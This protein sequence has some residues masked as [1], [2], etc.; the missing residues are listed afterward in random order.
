MLVNARAIDLIR[1]YQSLR[2]RDCGTGG[3]I[4][5]AGS[6]G[7]ALAT[8]LLFCASASATTP[9]TITFTTSP[10]SPATAGNAYTVSAT[11]SSG[12][13][14]ALKAGGVCSVNPPRAN[15]ELRLGGVAAPNRAAPN[16]YPVASQMTVYFL[17][18]GT[19]TIDAV[20]FGTAEYGNAE[21]VQRFTV[22]KDPSERITFLSSAPR[23]FVVGRSYDPVVRSSAGVGVSFSA[24]PRSVCGVVVGARSSTVRFVGAGTCTI[25][26]RQQGSSESQVPEARQSFSVGQDVTSGGT[27]MQSRSVEMPVSCPATTISSCEIS[28]RL[29]A[30]AHRLRGLHRGGWVTV[31]GAQEA[32]LGGEQGTLRASLNAVGTRLLRRSHHLAV[33]YTVRTIPEA[34]TATIVVHVYDVG[35]PAPPNGCYDTKCP[36]DSPFYVS[37]LGAG[38]K[39]GPN[40]ESL[41]STK[42]KEQTIAV[43][44]GEYEVGRLEGHGKKVTVAAG[45]TVEVT[46]Y[47]SIP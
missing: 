21:Q 33:K 26:V 20:S 13:P 9:Q 25:D 46:L 1:E 37:R 36:T 32:L 22:A 4:G 38:E 41:S 30:K 19:C 28:L 8:S 35:G 39:V 45:Q 31:G 15:V 18:A 14:V 16:K 3:S 23:G 12:L 2:G 40:Q 5:R 44:P 24:V 43:A 17:S 10:P 34:L 7:A 6:L 29:A 42:T 47:V 27:T 11:S